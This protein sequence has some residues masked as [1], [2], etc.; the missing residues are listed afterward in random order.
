MKIVIL[1]DQIAGGGGAGVIAWNHALA[2]KAKG[3]EVAIITSTQDKKNEGVITEGGLSI[4]RIYVKYSLGLRAYKSLNNRRV[5]KKIEGILASYKPDIVHAHN[6]HL[7]LSYAALAAA[8]K[9]TPAVFLTIHDSMPFHYSKLF[10]N[11]VKMNGSDVVSYKVS[12]WTQ[13]RLFKKSF[14][15][16]RNGIIKKYLQIPYKIFAVSGALAQALKDNGINNVEVLHN[17]I[18]VGDWEVPSQKKM[19]DEREYIFFGGRLSAAKGAEALISSMKEVLP[20]KSNARLLIVGETSEYSNRIQQ[21]AHKHGMEDLILFAGQ[22]SWAEMKHMYSL[23]TL[24]IVPSLCFDWFPTVVLEAMA[25]KKPVIATCFGGAKEAVV[26]GETGFVV[27][28][29]N[30]SELAD[31]ILFLLSNNVAAEKMGLTGYE[32]VQ[33]EFSQ[34]KHVETLLSWYAKARV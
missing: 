28:P 6:L 3:N 32:R 31:K 20:V 30:T 22:K 34:E 9:F 12:P 14:N 7:Y 23:A 26:N 19:E 18:D 1:A 17:G 29:R 16:F 11:T 10:P 33:R 21:F 8:R 24:V 13:F 4:Y 27:D 5:V 15:P 2:L 25:S